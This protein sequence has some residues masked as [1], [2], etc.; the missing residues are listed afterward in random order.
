MSLRLN[1]AFKEG[2]DVL[3][4]SSKGKKR[5]VKIQGDRIH[6]HKGYI[7]VGDIVGN[8]PGIVVR[9]HTG[10]EF[11]A[12]KPLVADY[13]PKLAR[14]TQVM[15]PKDLGYMVLS[16]GVSPGFK[17]LDAGTGSGAAA[18][19]MASLVKPNGKVFSYDVDEESIAVAKRNLER[20]GL[21]E[22][23]ELMHEDVKTAVF[24]EFFDAALMDLPDPWEALGNVS[25][26]LK[27][28]ARICIVLPT[29]NQL[30]KAYSALVASGMAHLETVEIFLR[31]I[32]PFQG[33]I[34]PESLMTGHTAYLMIGVKV[35]R[36][37]V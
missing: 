12:L 25:R 26:F 4:I 16:L 30:E 35:S 5:V 17:V 24:K 15:Y 22:Y 29:M 37:N 13:I 19:V 18:M 11:L 21:L 23:V 36:E 3:L 7:Q 10:D 8:Q 34:R 28:S 33:K 31:R 27:P 2:E 32:R 9:T 20:V 14:R 1:D 6:T